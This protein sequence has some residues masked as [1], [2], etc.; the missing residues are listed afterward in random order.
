M[1]LLLVFIRP[2]A[3]DTMVGIEVDYEG[4]LADLYKAAG[5]PI[6]RRLLFQGEPLDSYSTL[7]AD[8]G[9]SNEVILHEDYIPYIE[10]ESYDRI[11]EELIMYAMLPRTKENVEKYE[12]N[13]IEEYDNIGKCQEGMYDTDNEILS[14]YGSLYVTVCHSEGENTVYL[15]GPSKNNVKHILVGDVHFVPE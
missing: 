3:A 14:K 15:M 5:I 4:T 6:S 10:I 9:L 2:I 7:L 13:I 11:R 12:G 1:S 8:T